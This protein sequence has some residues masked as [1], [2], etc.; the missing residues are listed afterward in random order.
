MFRHTDEASEVWIQ[1]KYKNRSN[2]VEESMRDECIW[3]KPAFLSFKIYNL[4]VQ[5]V[6]RMI[7]YIFRI[8]V[9]VHTDSL[10]KVNL[11]YNLESFKKCD[12]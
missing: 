3:I 1:I 5:I 10:R 4:Y 9:I 12:S 11:Q 7:P 2:L 6:E 8:L